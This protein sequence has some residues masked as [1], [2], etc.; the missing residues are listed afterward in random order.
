MKAHWSYE[1]IDPMQE[2][3]LGMNLPKSSTTVTTFSKVLAMFLFVLFPIVAFILGVQYQNR[4]LKSSCDQESAFTDTDMSLSNTAKTDLPPVATTGENR[5]FRHFVPKELS[6][7]SFTLSFPAKWSLT[8]DGKVVA[9]NTYDDA[10]EAL[11]LKLDKAKSS[12]SLVSAPIGGGWCHFPEDGTME[13]PYGE[14]G[15][16]QDIRVDESGIWRR[17]ESLNLKSSDDDG[18]SLFTVCYKADKDTEFFGSTTPI[19][20]IQ[21]R[22]ALGDEESILQFDQVVKD[23]RIID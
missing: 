13:G 6:F 5:T 20:S 14:Y 17:S 10:S 15:A 19:G 7:K 1:I 11:F 2:T 4:V 23:A 16:Y 9:D 12:M 21:Y 8:L 18:F 3:K 22:V